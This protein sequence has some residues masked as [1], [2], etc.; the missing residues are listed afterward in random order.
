MNQMEI[1]DL[2]WI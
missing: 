1:F 2:P